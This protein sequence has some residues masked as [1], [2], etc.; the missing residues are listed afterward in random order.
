M[1][2]Q[3]I[4]T[5]VR[6]M[7]ND[8]RAPYRYSDAVLL[9]FVN[10]TLRRMSVL[11]PDLFSVMAEFTTTPNNVMQ[12]CPTDS[13]RLVEIFGVVGGDA[14]TEVSRDTMDSSYPGWRTDPA[15]TPVNFMR[16]TRNANQYFLYPAPTSGIT[17]SGEYI[18]TPPV[19]ELDDPIVCPEGAYLPILVDGTVF[20]VESIDDEHVSSGRAKL[21]LDSFVQALGVGL[22]SRVVTDFESAGLPFVNG[23]T[24][25]NPRT[26][27]VM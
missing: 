12:R 27:G 2:P 25:A 13:V 15:G 9:G 3:D 14:V 26:D 11:R 6:R 7:V 23:G 16:H 8:T 18:Q 19:Y 21:F 22:Q 1:T 4:I 5:E 17:L 24:R 20:L 10:Q